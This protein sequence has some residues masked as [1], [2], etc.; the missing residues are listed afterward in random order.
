MQ[1][2]RDL[3]FSLDKETLYVNSNNPITEGIFNVMKAF[4]KI[5]FFESFN[6]PVDNLPSNIEEISFER[7]FNQPV[8][9]LP[10]GLKKI[11]FGQY[12]N[13]PL[14]N[15][16]IGLEVLEF[17][18][19]SEF[20]QP[21]DN[22]PINLKKLFLGFSYNLPLFCLPEGLKSMN[23]PY[24]YKHSMTKFPLGLNE[25]ILPIKAPPKPFGKHWIEI[26][27]RYSNYSHYDC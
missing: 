2:N 27:D 8:D 11:K 23:I 14:D 1:V 3:L 4:K 26:R 12:F 15:L 22:L 25:V 24:R 21:L 18:G 17:V 7:D 16:P 19:H 5:Y 9:N 6:Q 10:M 20:N 13:Q